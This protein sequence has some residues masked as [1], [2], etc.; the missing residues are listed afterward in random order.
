N[1][2]TVNINSTINGG[3]LNALNGGVLN[4]NGGAILNGVTISSGTTANVLDTTYLQGTI[5]NQGN[6]ALPG[7]YLAVL[8]GDVTLKGGGTVSLSLDAFFNQA[9][10]GLTLHNVDNTIQGT[11]Q[12]GQNGLAID[13]QAAGK[14]VANVNGGMLFV[15]GGGTLTNAGTLKATNGGTLAVT[16]PLS[17]ADFAGHTLQGGGTYVINGTSAVSTIQI[18]SFGTGGSA[19]QTLGSGTTLTLNGTNANVH[20][21]D[22]SGLDALNLSANNGNL[23]LEGGYSL[24]AAPGSTFT[25]TG[26]VLVDASSALTVSGGNAYLQTGGET[27]VDGTISADLVDIQGGVLAG[28]NGTTAGQITGTVNNDCGSG[29]CGTVRAGDNLNT[30][31]DPPGNLSIGGDYIHN[32]GATLIVD[33]AG[34]DPAQTSQ[35][36]VAGNVQLLGAN[37]FL[38]ISLLNSYLPQTTGKFLFLTYAG[39]L[40]AQDFSLTDP[41]VDPNGVFKVDYATPGDIFLDFTATNSSVTPEPSFLLPVF[42]L[43]GLVVGYRKMRQNRARAG[44]E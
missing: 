19:V 31:I 42:G 14:I 34:A 18:N 27:Q 30:P 11:G 4:T 38:T 8:G 9:S 37:D 35:L 15:N 25:N 21:I 5:T 10:D 24:T 12:L 6:F 39:T 23:N 44:A 26:D 13:N 16:A 3:T 43:L 40:N 33:I 28:G 41:N 2:G 1:G 20:F 7:T 22:G 32:S 29:T 36:N 17:A